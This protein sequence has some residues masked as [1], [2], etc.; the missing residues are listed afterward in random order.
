MGRCSLH[1]GIV[2]MK[3]EK[4]CFVS[5]IEYLDM[6][7]LLETWKDGP[8]R[9]KS[10]FL[11]VKN[12]LLKTENT[13]LSFKSRPGVSYSLRASL[14]DNRKKTGPLLALVDIIDDDPE[15]R[16]LSICFY[17]EMITDPRKVGNLVPRGIL[18][19]D[20]YCFDLEDDDESMVAYVMERIDE[21]HS[22]II[23]L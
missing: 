5:G 9:I 11:K 8:N 14:K 20:G 21:V 3:T 16:W 18:G 7:D 12:K 2:G 10:V 6:S 4:S 13:S 23:A 15:K 1:G 17:E 19:V 22:H